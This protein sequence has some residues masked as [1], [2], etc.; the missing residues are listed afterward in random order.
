[1]SIKSLEMEYFEGYDSALIEFH[2]GVNVITGLSGHGKSSIVRALRWA[3]RND[4][5][6]DS[7]LSHF[8]DGASTISTV[9]FDDD[10][11][12][13]RE[14]GTDFNGYRLSTEED[15]F[16]ALRG[17]IPMQVESL[18]NMDY[19]SNIQKQSDFYFMLLQTPG[20]VARMFNKISGLEDMDIA[21]KKANTLYDGHKHK[22]DV[23]S[24]MFDRIEAQI[25]ESEWVPKADKAFKVVE[26]VSA[27]L[28]ALSDKSDQ[29]T[30]LI[31]DIVYVDS[32][33]ESLS[34]T[35]ALPLIVDIFELDGRCADL[36]EKAVDLENVL[37]SIESIDL[38]LKDI[39]LP[40][41]SLI[42][43]IDAVLIEIVDNNVR[44]S[45]LEALINGIQDLNE[46]IEVMDERIHEG[47]LDVS[48]CIRHSG[49]CPACEGTGMK[50]K[51]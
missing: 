22:F 19:E 8:A 33:I 44:Y 15:A 3:T 38:Q 36:E 31:N 41:T 27:D 14:R 4:P 46:D 50:E 20:Q 40:D 23:A 43:E 37:E 21:T 16:V 1:M 25:I 6:G 26:K 11:W 29:L 9:T 28:H 5:Q 35:S 24:T 10:E 47:K 42:D 2:E 7:M 48:S 51:A 32:E 12:V 39:T 34:D 18:C 17:K 30:D 45:T 13:S 49:I